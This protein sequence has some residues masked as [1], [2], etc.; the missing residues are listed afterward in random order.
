MASDIEGI[1]EIVETAS[2]I[3]LVFHVGQDWLAEADQ[4]AAETARKREA[5]TAFLRSPEFRTRFGMRPGT[6]LM[7]SARQ[8]P[9]DVLADMA[10]IGADVEVGTIGLVGG[11]SVALVACAACGRGGFASNQMSVTERGLTCPACFAAWSMQQDLRGRGSY[12][13]LTY[14]SGGGMSGWTIAR[15][16]IALAVVSLSALR[17]C[18]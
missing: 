14:P 6:I 11:P 10:R 15:I 2:A 17:A 18:S 16:L 7:K 12:G 13:S 9:P 1:D 8:P 4:A 3:Q 5:C